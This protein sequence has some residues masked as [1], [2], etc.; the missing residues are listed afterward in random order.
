[1]DLTFGCR[2]YD[3]GMR[4]NVSSGAPWEKD[5]GYSR[6]VRLGGVVAV[7]GTVAVDADGRAV[8]GNSYEQAKYALEKIRRALAE[9]GAS[10]ADVVRTRSFAA[11]AEHVAGLLKAHGEFFSSIRPA[12]TVVIVAGLIDPR[13]FVEIE[14]DAL[15]PQKPKRPTAHSVLR[16]DRAAIPRAAAKAAGANRRRKEKKP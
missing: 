14:V 16:L 13:F 7:S 9:C 10:L 2:C 11:G 1:M 12:A 3:E 6:A 15:L 5:V 4:Q 8:G